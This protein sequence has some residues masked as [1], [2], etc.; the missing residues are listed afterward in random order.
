MST[1][2]CFDELKKLMTAI[3]KI[4]QRSHG[5]KEDIQWILSKIETFKFDSTIDYKS[6]RETTFCSKEKECDQHL[7]CNDNDKEETCDQELDNFIDNLAKETCIANTKFDPAVSFDDINPYHFPKFLKELKRLFKKFPAWTNVMRTIFDSDIIVPPSA[8]SENYFRTAK[9]D[10]KANKKNNDVLNA[11]ENWKNKLNVDKNTN[12]T[13]KD[14]DTREITNSI[15]SLPISIGDSTAS[16]SSLTDLA[17]VEKP[18]DSP[19]LDSSLLSSPKQKNNSPL[20]KSGLFKSMSENKVEDSYQL[21]SPLFQS[22]PVKNEQ[23][24][25]ISSTSNALSF[26]QNADDS[27]SIILESPKKF[28]LKTEKLPTKRKIVQSE[29]M[30]HKKE[31][32]NSLILNWTTI[33]NITLEILVRNNEPVVIIIKQLIQTLVLVNQH[34]VQ[35][36]LVFHYKLAVFEIEVW[37]PTPGASSSAKKSLIK[38]RRLERTDEEDAQRRRKIQVPVEVPPVTNTYRIGSQIV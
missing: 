30:V 4:C 31:L 23:N 17:S 22:T 29:P 12:L 5:C 38:S 14:N 9:E 35:I 7:A 28:I 15:S 36:L 18:E 34:V 8:R 19:I 32:I 25:L 1:I 21:E 20:L 6:L 3:F 11:C 33:I 27:F 13:S 26:T 10:T 2:E 16:N 37:F 24:I